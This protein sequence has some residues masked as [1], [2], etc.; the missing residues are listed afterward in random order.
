MTKP[1]TLYYA[2]DNASLCVRLA[3]LE[4]GVPF[5]TVL[6]DRAVQGQVAPEYLALNPNGVIPTLMT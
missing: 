6:V 3:L 1:L 2:P 5:E 4:L